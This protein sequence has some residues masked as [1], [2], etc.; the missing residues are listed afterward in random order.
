MLWWIATAA[1]PD[2]V[3]KRVTSI[4]TEAEAGRRALG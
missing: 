2:T 3:A 4:V 1:R